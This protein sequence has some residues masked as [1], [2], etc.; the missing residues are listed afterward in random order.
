MAK[1]KDK[2]VMITGASSGIG[3]ELA[4]QFAKEGAKLVITARRLERLQDLA[5]ELE[6]MGTQAL[7][8]ACDVNKEEDLTEVVKQTHDAF[9]LIDVAI[10]NA[11]FGVSNTFE[12]LKVSDYRRQLETNVFGALNTCYA[13][14]DDLK[15]TKGRLSVVGSV[16]SYV[17]MPGGTPYSMS[18]YAVRAFCEGLYHE[19]KPKGIAVTLISPGF[20]ASEIRQV[21]NQ[22]E[23]KSEAKDPVPS[24]LVMKTPKAARQMLQAI[25]K[26]KRERIITNHGKIIV[27]LTRFTP[28]LVNFILGRAG[29]KTKNPKVPATKK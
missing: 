19:L 8:V 16:A 2:V 13:V 7:P 14:I 26:R 22:G 9:G 10:A 28:W 1:F 29:A 23:F 15:Q 18:K 27:W 17:S 12:K 24:F 11:G 3:A 6:A 25:Y 21:N 4:R 5:K 20:V